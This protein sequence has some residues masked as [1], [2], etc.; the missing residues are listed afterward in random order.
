MKKSILI[1]LSIA[2]ALVAAPVTGFAMSCADK[3]VCYYIT[4]NVDSGDYHKV[5]TISVPT[6]WK[7]FR[8]CRPWHCDGKYKDTNDY[9]WENQCIQKFPILQGKNVWVEYPN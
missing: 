7:I 1:A 6:C 3:V 5:G 4:P 2:I 8:H 9:Y